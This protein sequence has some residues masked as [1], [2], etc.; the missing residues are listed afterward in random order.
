MTC[1]Q[2]VTTV[3]AWLRMTPDPNHVSAVQGHGQCHGG[4][5][6]RGDLNPHPLYED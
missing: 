2:C 6:P 4:E 3:T 5:C 1:D